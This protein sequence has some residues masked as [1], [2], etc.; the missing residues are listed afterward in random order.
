MFD[1]NFDTVQVPDPNV[2]FTDTMDR[3]FKTNSYK[4]DDPFGNEHPYLFSHGGVDIYPDKLSPNLE[5]CRD[6]MA[7]TSTHDDNH[8]ETP[9]KPSTENT[10]NNKSILSMQDLMILHAKNI[11]PQNSKD[12]SKHIHTYMALTCKCT[13]FRSHQNKKPTIW[14]HLTYMKNNSK[15]LPWNTTPE[16]TNLIMKLITM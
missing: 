12:N 10:H 6:S 14:N 13:Q 1:D 8:S 16:M 15:S 9:N 2:K 4:Y 3:L 7:M 11:S 5:T